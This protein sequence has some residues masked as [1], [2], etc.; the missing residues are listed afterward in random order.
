MRKCT[1]CPPFDPLWLGSRSTRRIDN[2]EQERMKER[3]VESGETK[4]ERGEG[5]GESGEGKGIIRI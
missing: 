2:S 5:K 4:V 3:R 1:H